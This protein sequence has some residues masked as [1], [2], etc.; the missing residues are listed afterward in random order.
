GAFAVNGAK[1]WFTVA[2]P[3]LW[4]YFLGLLFVL[5]T[6]FLPRGIAGLA[7]TVRQR[8][9][10]RLSAPTAETPASQEARS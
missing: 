2:Y 10:A 7:Q 8:L 3:E 1:T 5:V 9:P 4:L 6:L